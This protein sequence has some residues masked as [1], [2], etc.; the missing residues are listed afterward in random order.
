MRSSDCTAL[1]AHPCSGEAYPLRFIF[2][3]V[4]RCRLFDLHL[5]ASVCSCHLCPAVYAAGFLFE[6]AQ[7]LDGRTMQSREMIDTNNTN[8]LGKTTISPFMQRALALAAQARGHCHPNPMVGCVIVRDGSIVGE[9]WHRQPGTAHAE[10]N[11]LVTAKE[12]ARGATAYVTLEPCN[13]WGRTPPCAQALIDAGVVKVVVAL[14]DPNPLAVGG[15]ETLRRAGILVEIGDGADEAQRLNERWLTYV[16]QGRP[17]VHLKVAMSLDA[18]VATCAGESQW[19]TGPAA[20][21]RGHHWRDSHEAILVGATTVRTD[22]PSLTC[23]LVPG[24]V[25]GSL[26]VRQPL[27]VVLAGERPLPSDARLFHDNAAPTL[28]ITAE[29]HYAMQRRA[30]AAASPRVEVISVAT[31]ESYPGPAAVLQ[32]LYGREVVGMLIEGGP[33]V[34]S[35]FLNANLVDR[36]S[37]FIAPKLLGPN[38]AS[39][40]RQVDAAQLTQALALKNLECS[41]V[42][43]DILLTGQIELD[44][45]NGSRRGGESVHRHR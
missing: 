43:E 27:R 23:R 22:N 21:R 20:R 28:V 45:Q 14:R 9:G 12:A 24:D 42:G 34:A 10:V 38:G 25:E 44:A 39:A 19:I 3:R 13:H 8:Q 11:A 6:W 17:F 40:F 30:L 32:C 15:A 5:S 4:V 18:K 29:A 16:Q 2:V 31:D 33:T 7:D 1:F 36:V 35:T 26:P 37:V 41:S